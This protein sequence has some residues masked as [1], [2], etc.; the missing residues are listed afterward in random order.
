MQKKCMGKCTSNLHIQLTLPMG[1]ICAGI[2]M[3]I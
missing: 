1:P 2:E 3:G